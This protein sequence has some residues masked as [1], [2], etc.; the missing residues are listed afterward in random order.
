MFGARRAVKLCTQQT[1]FGF[2]PIPRREKTVG[3]VLARGDFILRPSVR[4]GQKTFKT[5]NRRTVIAVIEQFP[6][7]VK[8]IPCGKGFP[9]GKHLA[10]DI[11]IAAIG[12]IHA[13]VFLGVQN[14]YILKGH[15]SEGRNH[16]V[17]PPL[18]TSLRTI[19]QNTFA[20]IGQP[21]RMIKKHECIRQGKP[22]FQEFYLFNF[23]RFNDVVGI[24]PHE[25]VPV[26]AGKG[27]IAG[28]RKIVPPNKIKDVRRKF[29]G[30]GTGIVR[31]TR[32]DDDDFVG[33]LCRAIQAPGKHGT[34]VFD[35]QAYRQRERF[36]RT[37]FFH[38]V[39]I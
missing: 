18:P 26:R 33:K 27:I 5:F 29:S 36:F 8:F 23:G 22:L 21:A 2:F 6:R 37:V 15:A 31:R 32:I 19:A 35:D 38:T 16:L 28:S 3:K 13:R 39:N 7:I 14:S 9:L 30:D 11:E 20:A 12:R 17:Y 10:I 24:Q 1:Q 25:I 34:F 4:A